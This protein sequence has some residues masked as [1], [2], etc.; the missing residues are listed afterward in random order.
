[1]ARFAIGY[2]AAAA[3]D[4]RD[5]LRHAVTRRVN[6]LTPECDEARDGCDMP[7]PAEVCRDCSCGKRF[8]T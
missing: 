2:S 5:L 1:M 8:N 6:D 3:R 4:L 7:W